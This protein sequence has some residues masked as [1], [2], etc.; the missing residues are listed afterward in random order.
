MC[1]VGGHPGPGLRNTDLNGS[2]N[3][4]L[5]DL[6]IVPSNIMLLIPYWFN[7]TFCIIHD[8]NRPR[9]LF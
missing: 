6:F 5:F 4:I 8:S 9:V 1:S 2:V 7:V 3:N